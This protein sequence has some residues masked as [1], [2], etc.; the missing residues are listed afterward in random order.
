MVKRKTPLIT[1]LIILVNILIFLNELKTYGT[2]ES[3]IAIIQSGGLYGEA[4]TENKDLIKHL[5]SAQFVH[6]GTAH[7]VS[8]MIS[9]ALIGPTMERHLGYIKFA[10]IY[11][12]SGIIG[13]I[14]V[15]IFSPATISAGA[16]TAI[17][18][19]FGALITYILA[20]AKPLNHLGITYGFVIIYNIIQTFTS[21]GI[22]VPGHIGGLLGGMLIGFFLQPKQE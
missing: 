18:G 22:S 3:P 21:T 12:L 5:I 6:I 17:F 2:T 1:G 11:L 13:N 14:A 10:I 9:L 4:I 15:Y 16:S 7:I 20:K 8:N 19:L